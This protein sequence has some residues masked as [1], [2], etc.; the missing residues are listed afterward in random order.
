MRGYN[1]AAIQFNVG[2]KS[3]VAFDQLS[4]EKGFG[5][6]QGSYFNKFINLLSHNNKS[7]PEDGLI[8]E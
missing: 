8:L 7:V 5:E 1:F 2:K 4:G 3:L 6:I